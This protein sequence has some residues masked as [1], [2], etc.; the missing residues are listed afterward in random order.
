MPGVGQGC[1]LGAA[2]QD[3]RVLG[4][5]VE[6]VGEDAQAGPQRALRRRAQGKACLSVTFCPLSIYP[7]GVHERG[8]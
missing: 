7:G 8:M 6:G 2:R 4:E 3:L 1:N 5:G